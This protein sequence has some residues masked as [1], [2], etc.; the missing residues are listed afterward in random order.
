MIPEAIT[1]TV[2]THP[3]HVLFMG[4]LLV[5]V[6][7]ATISAVEEARRPRNGRR[8]APAAGPSDVQTA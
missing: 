7:R 5:H 3:L 1:M 8:P 6:V 4:M 2:L